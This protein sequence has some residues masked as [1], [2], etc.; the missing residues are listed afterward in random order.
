MKTSTFNSPVYIGGPQTWNVAGGKTLTVN[1]PLHTIIS[2][3]TFSGAGDTIISG[4]IDGGG[5]ANLVGGATPGSLVKSGT[6]VLHFTGTATYGV[7]MTISA[8]TVR[9]EQTGAEVANYSG[10][11]KSTGGTLNKTNPGTIVFS[12]ANSY[13]IQTTI[14]EGAIRA[15]SGVGLPSGSALNLNG[16][17][18]QCNSATPFTRNLSSSGSNRMQWSSGGGGFAA[19]DYPMTVNIGGSGASLTWGTTVGS[20]IVGT[21]KFGCTTANN[22]TTFQN[23]ISLGSSNRTIQADDNL[24][25]TADYAVI[26]GKITYSSGTAGII[27]TGAGLLILT[28]SANDYNG[29]TTI[30]SGALQ[31]DSGVGLPAVSVL[32]LN[33]GVLQCNSAV[34]FTRSLG[35]SGSNKVEWSNGGGFSAGNY[36]M[37]IN[38]GG[39]ATPS[40]VT[41]GGAVGSGIVGTLLFGSTS[42]NDVTTFRNGINLS[43]AMRTIQVDDNVNSF[44]DRAEISGAIVA[45]SG[46]AGITKTGPGLLVLSGANTYNGNTT[47]SAGTL[48]LDEGVGLPAGSMLVLDGGVLQGNTTT[49][50]THG[51]NVIQWTA[52]GGGFSAGNAGPMTINFGGSG[53]TLPWGTGVGNSIMG[54]LKLNSA[55]STNS[56]TFQNGVNL[57]GGART[58]EVGGNTATFSGVISDA[59]GSGSLTKTG[60]GTLIL[61]GAAANTSTGTTILAAGTLVLAKTGGAAAIAGNMTLTTP[62][63]GTNTYLQLGGDN[64]LASTAVVTLNPTS[65]AAAYFELLGHSTTVGGLS[66]TTTGGVVENTQTETGFGDVTLTINGSANCTYAGILRD[67]AGGS[68]RLALVKDGTG[69]QTFTGTGVNGYTGGLTVKNGTLDFSAAALPTSTA[70]TVSGGTLSTGAWSSR[71]ARSRSPADSWRAPAR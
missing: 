6:G 39:S 38:L 34:T 55:T 42:A 46:T 10:V 7:P 66:G 58:L 32:N 30:N 14:S 25:S 33:G 41:W 4:P 35:T 52:N 31:A 37:T 47:I 26:S 21:L 65:D 24:N 5:T 71:S 70:I 48:Q 62:G 8:G 64:Q 68:G 53:A 69:T 18:L 20:R 50:F 15:D 67:S 56:I 61:A 28:S 9:F 29:L 54:T 44:A 63:N 27:K 59:V 51:F 45:G 43:G 16:G 3:V 36:P 17:V 13:T 23:G 12:G 22:V 40:T 19:S 60:P 57:G 49:A 1:G 11:I 2:N